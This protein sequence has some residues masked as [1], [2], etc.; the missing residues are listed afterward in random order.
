VT[1]ASDPTDAADGRPAA[2]FLPAGGTGV[3]GGH[4]A[5]CRALALALAAD[6][7]RGVFALRP[8]ARDLFSWL[9]DG[10]VR[11]VDAADG[12]G[13][14][15]RAAWAVV[16]DY[17]ATA[18]DE[19]AAARWADAVLAMEDA[20]GRRHDADVLLDP[21]PGRRA[22]DYA[23]L[24]PARTRLL[25]GPGHALIAP[26]FRRSRR[27]TAAA[28]RPDGPPRVAVA[29]GATDP[30]DATSAVLAALAACAPAVGAADVVLGR[31]APHAGRVRAACA[32]M[33]FPARLHVDPPDPAALLA[34]ADLAVGAAGTGALERCALGL[35]SVALV[36][37]DNQRDVAAGVAAAGAALVVGSP[38]DAAALA[39]A[40]GR[41]LRD[42]EARRATGRRAAALVDGLGARRTS[43]AMLPER[44]P[45]GSALTLRRAGPEDEALLLGWQRH[46]ATRRHFRVPRPPSPDDHAA[47]L[48]A[49]L[50]DPD[51]RLEICE[52]GGRPVGVV[53]VDERADGAEG[54]VSIVAAP[55]GRGRGVGAAALRALRRLLPEVRLV[56]EVL[57]GNEA[58]HRLFRAAGYRLDGG[59]YVLEAAA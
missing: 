11:T 37:F 30:D 27:A 42:E 46:P 18:E 39:A 26:G 32:G 19:A 10:S 43:I 9:G 45:D 34:G 55:E 33:P 2:V 5:R 38:G 49:R 13:A 58:S 15:G 14:F 35:P 47:W 17:G 31:A 28:P 4:L 54:E 29:M 59:L 41:L 22:A 8:G 53:R 36:C 25:L 7:M 20:P 52:A 56:A 16:D 51:C 1:S 40:V 24:V 44:L 48:S 12:P 3:G 23:G 50:S 21:T 6:G 57:P